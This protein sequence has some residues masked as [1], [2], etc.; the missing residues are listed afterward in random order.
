MSYKLKYISNK[1]LLNS[2][3]DFKKTKKVYFSVNK[4]KHLLQN[5]NLPPFTAIN[6]HG[7][8]NTIV[9]I[10]YC[11]N[12]ENNANSNIYRNFKSIKTQL[13]LIKKDREKEVSNLHTAHLQEKAKK[14]YLT[15]NINKKINSISPFNPNSN[16]KQINFNIDNPSERD[17]SSKTDNENESLKSSKSASTK[18]LKI[19][20]RINSFKEDEYN[21]DNFDNKQQ[22]KGS[23]LRS[24][25][26]AKQKKSK[27]K[28]N[29]NSAISNKL[30]TI[31][32]EIDLDDKYLTYNGTESLP[33]LQTEV[34][35][36]QYFS[37]NLLHH[38]GL[39]ANETVSQFMNKTKEIRLIKFANQHK[40]ERKNRLKETFDNDNDKARDTLVNLTI[41]KLTFYDQFLN[42]FHKYCRKVKIQKEVEYKHLYKL[43][44]EKQLLDLQM[45]QVELKLI[46]QKEL[47]EKYM[48]YKNFLLAVK[49]SDLTQFHK[50][51][52]SILI[53]LDENQPIDYRSLVNVNGITNSINYLNNLNYQSLPK[54][55][56]STSNL[57]NK[58]NIPKKT[59]SSFI[60][61]SSI[62]A[63]KSQSILETNG[64]MASSSQNNFN[65]H[66]SKNYSSLTNI[67]SNDKIKRPLMKRLTINENIL[68]P[69][70][71]IF[72]DVSELINCLTGIEDESL[73]L[74]KKYN[75]NR[76][77]IQL[78][79]KSITE[80]SEDIN[81]IQQE[82][83]TQISQMSFNL[84]QLKNK[85][86]NLKQ[87]RLNLLRNNTD[88]KSYTNNKI[89]VLTE[90][91]TEKLNSNLVCIKIDKNDQ[92]LIHYLSLIEQGLN[93]LIQ[94][95]IHYQKSDPEKFKGLI[96]RLDVQ[97]RRDKT[98]MMQMENKIKRKRI[99][100]KI[101]DKFNKRAVLPLRRVS[102]KFVPKNENYNQTT[103][104][105]NIQVNIEDYLFND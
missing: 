8:S 49:T 73:I 50:N 12:N 61:N 93:Y 82:S 26:E 77:I 23:L 83:K 21:N 32:N 90:K 85:N 27:V 36:N 42:A 100:E 41:S 67:T 72:K 6:N 75:K 20:S 57:A 11:Y 59:K 2:I 18:K 54:S 22:N 104:D 81:N 56:S 84:S 47:I 89:K 79:S 40:L 28:F 101:I 92:S 44:Q 94:K 97:H 5:S 60:A 53:E 9:S 68:K 78:L 105:N 1:D 76:E 74:L 55:F 95:S 69:R 43:K 87:E 31:N 29:V 7:N 38:H 62:K 86:I 52:L 88:N 25:E 65:N 17:S 58:N 4:S 13:M 91:M 35:R 33:F 14:F 102:L 16:R 24:N 99:V 96:K 34:L 64:F 45:K 63:I 39:V 98:Q 70:I 10:N 3:E 51:K 66:M 48:E 37:K 46:K 103:T 71:N 80:R 15:E 19:I 30:L